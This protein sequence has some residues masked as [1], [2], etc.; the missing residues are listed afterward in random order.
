MIIEPTDPFDTKPE[1]EKLRNIA[2][3][4]VEVVTKEPEEKPEPISPQELYAKTISN[5]KSDGPFFQF[6][7]KK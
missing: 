4:V 3:S 5:M 2:T 7:T 6:A 1:M